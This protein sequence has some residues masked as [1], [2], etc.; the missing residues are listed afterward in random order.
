MV[1]RLSWWQETSIYQI[2]PRSYMDSNRDGIGDLQGIIGRLDY[3][4][5]L[6]FETI[7]LSPFFSG[8]QGDWGYDVSDYCDVAPEYGR[9]ADAEELIAEVHGRRMR[10]LFDLVMNH[11]SME[12]PWFLESRSSRTDPRRDWYIWRDGRGKRP[13]NNWQAIPGGPGWHLDERT[14][15]WYFASFLPFQPDLNYRN[16]EVKEAMFDVVRFWLD[17]GVDGFRLD[18]FHSI[19]KDEQFRDNPFSLRYVPAEDMR[20]GYFQEW[21]F[22]LNRPETIE[23][24]KELRALVDSYSPERVLL[25]E[26]FADDRTLRRFLGEDEPDGLNLLFSWG[27]P[28]FKLDARFF[29]RLLAHH[30]RHYPAPYTPVNVLGN[31]DRKRVVSRVGNDPRKAQALA[32]FQFTARGVPVTYYGE[33]IG[34]RESQLPARSAKDPLGQRYSWAPN[35]LAEF[36]DLYLN[37]DGCRTP[38]QWDQS[39]NAGFCKAGIDP[40]LPVPENHRGINVVTESAADSSLLSLYRQLLALRRSSPALLRGDL[41]PL[42]EEQTGRNLLGFRREHGQESLLVLINFSNTT[43]CMQNRSGCDQL[44]LAVGSDEVLDLDRISLP[45]YSGLVLANRTNR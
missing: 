8:P 24:A 18:I 35:W 23:L 36:L 13:P 21:K 25:G 19:F 32:L 17:K 44:L 37:R 22:N 16:L 43:G 3:I 33:E 41:H 40:W 27:L 4:K 26:I 45:P 10:V 42:G 29:R 11:S 2:Y 1:G 39:E 15:Q 31:H 14:G 6:G 38:M 9:L 12:H 30:E 5:E 34:M 7:W 20:A 28:A